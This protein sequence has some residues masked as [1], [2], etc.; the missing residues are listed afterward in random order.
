MTIDQ[1]YGKNKVCFIT[2]S[3]SANGAMMAKRIAQ[4]GYDIAL[5]HSGRDEEGAQK[6]A[7]EIREQSG[8]NCVVFSEDLTKP[9]SSRRLFD[10]FQKQFD[11]LDLFI[12][13]AGITAG[14]DLTHMNP[15]AFE[16]VYQVN[17]TGTFF[18]VQYA[19]RIMAQKGIPGQIVLISSNHHRNNCPGYAPYGCMKEALCRLT[20]HCALELSPYNIRIT[21]LA[22]GWIANGSPQF[23]DPQKRAQLD[24]IAQTL[25]LRRFVTSEE[26]ADWS[27]FLTTDAGKSYSGD[28]INIDGGASFLDGASTDEIPVLSFQELSI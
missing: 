13:N 21:C 18:T 1:S 5:H 16:K 17:W 7:R 22:P 19:A 2:G 25:P 27:V 26:L 24:R 10:Q 3:G 20:E 11:R 28:T 4:F 6:T 8:V 23:S 9:H 12:A 15:A 14:G